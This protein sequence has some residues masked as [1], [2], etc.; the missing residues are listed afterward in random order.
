L[1]LANGRDQQTECAQDSG[2]HRGHRIAAAPL[3]GRVGESGGR[4]PLDLTFLLNGHVQ[5]PRDLLAGVAV[6][7]AE[8]CPQYQGLRLHRGQRRQA[9]FEV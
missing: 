1:E 2:S 9:A 3:R 8:T 6:F 7:E 5:D 4:L